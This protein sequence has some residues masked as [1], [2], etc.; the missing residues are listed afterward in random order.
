VQIQDLYSGQRRLCAMT[1]A[2]TVN[3]IL[4]RMGAVCLDEQGALCGLRVS[5]LPPGKDRKGKP[6]LEG[7]FLV[8]S[9]RMARVL[10]DLREHGRVLRVNYGIRLACL[11]ASLRA[12][13]PDLPAC[14]AA[15]ERIQPDFPAAEA[16]LRPHDVIVALDGR[17]YRDP[18]EL[19][20]EMSRKPAG[21]PVRFDVVRKGKKL[22]IEVTPVER[23]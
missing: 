14:A 8:P 22:S 21:K 9:S 5:G 18:L 19:F 2:V 3:A 4:P 10:S 23:K 16:G 15:I 20:E 7:H 12:Q 1:T 17:T 6:H 13:M 11:P